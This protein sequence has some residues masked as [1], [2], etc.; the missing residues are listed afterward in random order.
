MKETLDMPRS[1]EQLI[2]GI[3]T[4]PD[5][6]DFPGRML[7]A[8]FAPI[9]TQRIAL[10]KPLREDL[11]LLHGQ[12]LVDLGC[13]MSGAGHRLACRFGARAYIGV[14][15]FFENL[16]PEERPYIPCSIRSLIPV[17]WERQDM[18]AFLERLPDRSVSILAT[19]IDVCVIP[20]FRHLQSIG[21]QITRVLHDDGLAIV[22]SSD[23][24]PPKLNR[25]S[26][27]LLGVRALD[28]IDLYHRG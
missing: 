24:E 1:V 6:K 7:D 10:S 21:E 16:R 14:D 28:D 26:H 4:T 11:R 9:L 22:Y 19:G 27:G 25:T 15:A 8:A 12:T 23:I 20:S 18:L 13:G 5:P 3:Q 17:A 2:T